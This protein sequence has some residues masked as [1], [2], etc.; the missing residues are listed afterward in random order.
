MSM[1]IHTK[2][3]TLALYLTTQYISELSR[4]NMGDLDSRGL[5]RDRGSMLEEEE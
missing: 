5:E 1:M 3:P 2:D 4:A